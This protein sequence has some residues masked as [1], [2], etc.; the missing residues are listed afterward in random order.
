[1]TPTGKDVEPV[2]PRPAVTGTILDLSGLLHC[3]HQFLYVRYL[4]QISEH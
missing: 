3:D 2:W 1:V 4:L